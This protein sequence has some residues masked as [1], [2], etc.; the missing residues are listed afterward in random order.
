MNVCMYFQVHQPYRFKKYSVFDVGEKHDYF[1]S[2]KNKEIMQKV[3]KKCYLP[4]NK[5][6]LEQIKKYK[7]KFKIAF[8]IT[9]VALEQMKEYAPEVIESFKELAK[10]GCVEFLA[11]TYYH[12]LS[13]LYSKEEFKKQVK[14]HSELIEELFNFKPTI[15]RHTEL[16]YN[17]DLAEDVSKLGFKGILAEGADH[18]LGWRSPNYLYEPKNID[19]LK[20]LL[21]NFKLSDDIAFR[22]S[23]KEWSEYPLSAEK[24]SKWIKDQ[25]GDVVN[26]F[27]DYETFGEH[28][29]KE[30][31]IFEFLK[32]LP[33]EILKED[34][35]IWPSEAIASFKSKGEFDV[36]EFISWADVER[37]ISA[38]LGNKMQLEATKHL[39]LLEKNIKDTND[40]KL[41]E[42]WR[43][44]QTSD[45]VYY[46]STKGLNDGNVHKYFNPYESPYEAFTTFMNI[47]NDLVERININKKE[48]TQK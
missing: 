27:M 18:L 32:K 41:I 42:E 8:S 35:F 30:S 36:K 20:L 6:L 47:I 4:A 2:E 43:K 17:N 28:Q 16:I 29:W 40:E 12:S 44:L 37:D 46:M 21:K 14:M 15:F 1:D 22:F 7:S 10:T 19:K 24:F 31:G 48:L 39:Y 13:Y 25:E 5:I 26:L 23:D 3:A 45:H 33:G 38:W 9:G 34:S 11:E